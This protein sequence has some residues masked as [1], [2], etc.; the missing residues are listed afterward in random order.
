MIWLGLNALLATPVAWE[1][2]R[3]GCPAKSRFQLSR[4]LLR[5]FQGKSL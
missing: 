1:K 2:L 4:R 5:I 3:P